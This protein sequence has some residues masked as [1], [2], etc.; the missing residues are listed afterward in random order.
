[1]LTATSSKLTLLLLGGPLTLSLW[2]NLEILSR[3]PDGSNFWDPRS[4]YPHF[5]RLRCS[6]VQPRLG[7]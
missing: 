1:M 2:Q 6:E 5:P 3:F 7:G 4:P